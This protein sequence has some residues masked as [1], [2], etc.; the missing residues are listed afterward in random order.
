MYDNEDGVRQNDLRT[1]SL[2]HAISW[3]E[4]MNILCF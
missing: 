2:C 1:P 3:G 4:R